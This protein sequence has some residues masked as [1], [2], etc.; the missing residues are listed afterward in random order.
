MKKNRIVSYLL[1]YILSWQDK[2]KIVN[3]ISIIIC[4][5]FLGI[6]PVIQTLGFQ[7]EG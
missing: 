7:N 3:E 4:V 5:A 6:L 2:Y 1:Q